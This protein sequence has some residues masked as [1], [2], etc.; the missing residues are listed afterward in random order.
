MTERIIKIFKTFEEQEEYHLDWMRSSTPIQRFAALFRMQ[1]FT[2][3]LHKHSPNKRTIIIHHG[4]AK[5]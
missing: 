3:A 5:P 2:N 4:S 1:Q